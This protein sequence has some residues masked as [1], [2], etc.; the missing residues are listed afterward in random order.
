MTRAMWEKHSPLMKGNY[1]V[2]RVMLSSNCLIFRNKPDAHYLCEVSWHLNDTTR[3]NVDEQTELLWAGRGWG[4]WFVSSAVTTIAKKETFHI[5]WSSQDHFT[6]NTDRGA[7]LTDG[8]KGAA[9]EEWKGQVKARR[10]EQCLG[11]ETGESLI[12]T[13]SHRCFWI[14]TEG[15]DRRCLKVR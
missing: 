8:K 15:S 6:E 10:W 1:E 9:R 3:S 12:T 5:A 7:A 11:V 14:Q 2:K 4:H 13:A